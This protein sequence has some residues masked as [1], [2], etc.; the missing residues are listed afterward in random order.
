MSVHTMVTV[1][2]AGGGIFVH[3][4]TEP[5]DRYGQGIIKFYDMRYTGDAPRGSQGNGFT[6]DGQFISAYHADQF[7][8]EQRGG[9]VL[10]G[11]VPSWR[12][13]AAE[14]ADVQAWVRGI[15]EAE[16]TSA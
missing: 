1:S 16:E 8:P 12:L 2:A 11:G 15:Y 9:L 6:V 13:D 5:V 14:H 7:L 4:D 3:L 10:D